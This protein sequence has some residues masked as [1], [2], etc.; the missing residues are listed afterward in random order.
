MPAVLV[1]PVV[2]IVL[3][4]LLVVM[5]LWVCVVQVV[6]GLLVAMVLGS[7]RGLWTLRPQLPGRLIGWRAVGAMRRWPAGKRL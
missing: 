2:L 5:V 3:M 7:Q 1:V 4:V 6:V